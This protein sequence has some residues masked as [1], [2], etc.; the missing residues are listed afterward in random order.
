[1]EIL[2]QFV[3]F[4]LCLG[5]HS[6]INF[7]NK[8]TYRLQTSLL[9]MYVTIPQSLHV[10]TFLQKMVVVSNTRLRAEPAWQH[11]CVPD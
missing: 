4:S 3:Y 9:S 11:S 6:F 1:M 8:I 2:A 7:I 5:E 10:R